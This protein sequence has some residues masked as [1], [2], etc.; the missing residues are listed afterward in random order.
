VPLLVPA[1]I[2]GTMIHLPPLSTPRLCTN[3]ILDDK[4]V[5]GGRREDAGALDGLAVMLL[6]LMMMMIF[7]L[8][9]QKPQIAYRHIP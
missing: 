9:M 7:C 3:L 1:L 4:G 6:S 5:A 8:F 2:S